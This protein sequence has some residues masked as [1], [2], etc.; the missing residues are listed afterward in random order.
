[1]C[2]VVNEEVEQIYIMNTEVQIIVE[3]RV[4]NIKNFICDF[5]A[6]LGENTSDYGH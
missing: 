1:M 4:P 5:A 6:T 3:G 2:A